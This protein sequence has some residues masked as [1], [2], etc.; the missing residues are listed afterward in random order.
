MGV[1][2]FSH[3]IVVVIL[4]LLLFGRG[5]VSDLMSDFAK[6]IKSF[7]KGLSDDEDNKQ[8]QTASVDPKRITDERPVNLAETRERDQA[9]RDPK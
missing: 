8:D 9:D 7:K 1:F 6:G 4:V 5:R 2:S 3:L